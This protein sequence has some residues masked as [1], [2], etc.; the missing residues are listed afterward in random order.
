MTALMV[1]NR[2]SAW[3]NTIE[4]SDSKT[5]SVTSRPSMPNSWK[6]S[7][8]I[9]V[10]RLWNA[11]RQCM[12]FTV[13]LPV[14]ATASLFTWYGVRSLIRSAQTLLSSPIETQTSV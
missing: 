4:C 3:S 10:S 1:C 8:P 13:G 7:S 14:R 5:S 6:M 12:N 9:F 2:F 11:G